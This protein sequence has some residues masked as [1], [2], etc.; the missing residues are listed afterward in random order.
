MSSS[1]VSCPR[2][3]RP[4]TKPRPRRRFARVTCA[5]LKPP[6]PIVSAIVC[7]TVAGR[8]IY[9]NRHVLSCIHAARGSPTPARDSRVARVRPLDLAR[10]FQSAS[11]TH[12]VYDRVR[13]THRAHRVHQV[14]CGRVACTASSRT[15]TTA[16][17]RNTCGERV[18]GMG[19][20][21]AWRPLMRERRLLSLIGLRPDA[22][23]Y[24]NSY[25]EICR[26]DPPRLNA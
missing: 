12:A 17:S 3:Y 1:G 6:Y 16:E 26:S 22:K 15:V 20:G 7:R 4:C 18:L 5:S 14:A 19:F 8:L 21:V 24:G 25:A 13:S 10:T 2:R 11:H 23:R 9:T